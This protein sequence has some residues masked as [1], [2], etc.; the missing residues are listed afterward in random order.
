LC[1]V[2]YT[3][4]APRV[5]RKVIDIVAAIVVADS[6]SAPHQTSAG[7]LPYPLLYVV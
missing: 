2:R 5:K 7:C 6:I 3:R 4:R 1:S